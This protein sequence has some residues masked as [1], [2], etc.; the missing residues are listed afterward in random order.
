[1]TQQEQSKSQDSELTYREKSLTDRAS[2]ALDA[3]PDGVAPEKVLSSA[4]DLVR[5]IEATRELLQG[6]P[7]NLT[8]VAHNVNDREVRVVERHNG[9]SAFLNPLSA[10][11]IVSGSRDGAIGVRSE[12][13]S[14][15]RSSE[16]VEGHSPVVAG[17]YGT[18]VTAYER[19][20]RIWDGDHV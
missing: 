7:N 11:K 9:R 18:A 10:G 17:C 12:N 13:K 14:G 19:I 16:M 4:K 8:S 20:I 15:E 1:M 5:K 2:K 6:G 3:L